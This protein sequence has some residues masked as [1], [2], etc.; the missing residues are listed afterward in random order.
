MKTRRQ[1]IEF[2]GRSTVV[3]AAGGAALTTLQSCVSSPGKSAAS[4]LFFKPISSSK[5]DDVILPRGFKY[6]VLLKQGD[7]IGPDLQFGDCADY[8]AFFAGEKPD[9]AYLWVNHEYF[10]PQF[11][12]GFLAQ[13]GIKK[14]VAQMALE[15]TL[16]GGSLVELLRKNNIWALVTDS[17]LNQRWDANSSIKFSGSHRIH[18]KRRAIGT[19]ANCA[20]GVTPWKTVLTCEENYHQY[21]GEV[22]FTDGQRKMIPV[23]REHP[24]S[25]RSLDQKPPEHYGWVVEVDYKNK[26][27][28]KHVALGRFAHEGATCV[29]A[30]DGRCVVY[31]GDDKDDEFFYKFVSAKAG[32]LDK[33]I[34]YVANFSKNRWM[35]LDINKNSELK[36]AFKTQTD[37]LIR[38]REAARLV[39]ATPLDRPEDCKIDPL[40][41]AIFLA[42]TNN[43]PAG[44]PHGQIL[45][46]TESHGSYAAESFSVET[47]KTGGEDFSCPDNLA[48]DSEG[49]LWITS[50]M[51]EE[52]MRES[53]FN[54]FG[55]NGLFYVPLKG[56]N[57][58]QIFQFASAPNDAEFT[59]PSFSA[60]GKTLFLSVQH[61]GIGTRD[62]SKP[63]SRWPDRGEH[64]PRSAVIQIDLSSRYRV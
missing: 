59:G 40:T 10:A 20:G 3:A 38:T 52:A 64:F 9:Q 21:Y 29:E 5:A 35:P 46:F 49:D 4:D 26:K 16:V 18:G 42:C 27:A 1:F 56:K 28:V 37:L 2:I 30:A 63:T 25:W 51:S 13:D 15:K 41:G 48:F 53:E 7:P 23:K 6:S 34:L 60:D 22:S 8:T 14:T 44:R 39:G 33:G 12:S 24:M 50:D 36:K 61:P 57:A 54:K 19:L 43:K 17:P 45:K 31:M 55:N 62:L 11:T 58:G 32:Q 47:F